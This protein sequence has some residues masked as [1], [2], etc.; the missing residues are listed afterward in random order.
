VSIQL[1]L[2][3]RFLCR[4]PLHSGILSLNSYNSAIVIEELEALYHESGSEVCVC[5]IFFRYTEPAGFTVRNILE[6]LVKQTLERHPGCITLVEDTY[7]QHLR[8]ST[9]PNEAQLVALLRRLNEN[10]QTTFYVLDALDEAPT[11]IQLAIIKVLA[12]LNVKLFITSRPLPNVE[13]KFP[14]ARSFKIVAQDVDVELHIAKGIEESPD[15]Q[16]VLRLVGLSLREEIVNSI[17]QN[18][19]G[20]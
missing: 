2:G 13:S 19:G 15:L 18:C 6:V 3:R 1:V 16:D 20:M 9:E 12:S 5:Y 14:Q 8:E 7:A 10:I 17:K 11:K 4:W